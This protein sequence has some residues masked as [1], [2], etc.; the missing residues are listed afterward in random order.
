[1]NFFIFSLAYLGAFL[2]LLFFWFLL[3]FKPPVLFIDIYQIFPWVMLKCFSFNIYSLKISLI[4]VVT[5]SFQW[6]YFWHHYHFFDCT[7]NWLDFWILCNNASH[8]IITK[9]N[10]FMKIIRPSFRNYFFQAF[11]LIRACIGIGVN[12]PMSV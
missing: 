7:C 12:T 10:I 11:F 4:I 2:I 6:L 5:I 3:C 8:N 9:F 1:M